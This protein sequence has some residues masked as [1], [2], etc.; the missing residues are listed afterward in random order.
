MRT[1]GVLASVLLSYLATSRCPLRAPWEP[2]WSA[3]DRAVPFVGTAF[4]VYASHY[5]LMVGGLYSLKGPERDRTLRAVLWATAAASAV[6]LV[7]PVAH[8]PT[9]VPAGAGP[10]LI[11]SFLSAVD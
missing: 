7:F 1:A 8:P 6:F 11:H 4:Y 10:R 2:G 3:L 5:A 9:P